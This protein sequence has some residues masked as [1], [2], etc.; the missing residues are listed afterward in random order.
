[1]SRADHPLGKRARGWVRQPFCDASTPLG[2]SQSLAEFAQP[3]QRYVERSEQ[4]QLQVWIVELVAQRQGSCQ[5]R[6]DLAT[7]A[8]TEHQ[9]HTQRAL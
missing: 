9:R 8:T 1:M 4:A 2:D 6:L 5:R 3:V 7:V